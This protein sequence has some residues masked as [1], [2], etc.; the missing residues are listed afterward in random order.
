MM[1]YTSKD[2]TPLVFIS[3]YNQIYFKFFR[4]NQIFNRK[5]N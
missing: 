4:M 1:L 5:F 3:R 2:V